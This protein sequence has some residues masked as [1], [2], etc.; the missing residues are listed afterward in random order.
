[1]LNVGVV[2]TSGR[3]YGLMK[4]VVLKLTD[5][6]KITAVCDLYPDRVEDA[7]KLV[8]EMSGVLPFGTT[9]YQQLLAR[10][11]VDAVLI[12]CAWEA[13]VPVAIAAMRLGKAVGTEV[14]GAYDIEDCWDLVKTYEETKTPFM[15]LE[16]C[17][18]GRREMMALNMAEQGVFGEVVHCTGAYGHDLRKEISFGK[19]NRHYRLRNYTHRNCENY[20]TH[21]LG[22]IA[23]ILHIND[24]N[25][26]MKLSTAVSK[27][28]G[29]HQYIKDNKSDDADLMSR[30]FNQGDVVTTTITC[31]NG[32][33]IV[34]T[35]DTTLPRYYCRGLSV[36]GTKGMYEEATD[37]VFLDDEHLEFEANWKEKWG[38]AEEYTDKYEHPVWKEYLANEMLGA[39][40]GMDGL[41][42]CAFFDSIIEGKPCPIDVYDAVAWMCITPLSEQ[43]IALGGAPVAIPDFTRGKWYKHD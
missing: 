28:A 20:P 15:F 9:D 22:P 14:G 34:I 29:L 10:E 24:G 35:L 43:S 6:V 11:D 26:M 40:G 21:E 31:A 17:C 5:K 25:R 42:L 41:V 30:T 32:E 13:H 27:A 12:T 33:T 7:Q 1:M 2:G 18:Y 37:S 39:H 16:N 38:N 3:G 36:R 8:E 23:R 4:D 19:E